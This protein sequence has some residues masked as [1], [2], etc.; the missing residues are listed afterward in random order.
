[1]KLT[2]EQKRLIR[3]WRAQRQ[4]E[5]DWLTNTI[6]A[7]PLNRDWADYGGR[8]NARNIAA[9]LLDALEEEAK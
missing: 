9:L 1:M 7:L 2:K 3:S 4:G 5:R 6:A 8:K